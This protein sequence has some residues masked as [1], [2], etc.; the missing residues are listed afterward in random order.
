MNCPKLSKFIEPSMSH[1][2]YE[3]VYGNVSEQR[4]ISKLYIKLLHAREEMIQDKEDQDQDNP[5]DDEDDLI[6]LPGAY[7]G[8]IYRE[9]NIYTIFST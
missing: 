5:E 6:C 7:I 3:H 8:P 1:I 2:K 4:E 9:I